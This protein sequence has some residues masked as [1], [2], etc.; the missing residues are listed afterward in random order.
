MVKRI[1]CL[2]LMLMLDREQCGTQ[3]RP[4]CGRIFCQDDGCG[5]CKDYKIFF[6][7]VNT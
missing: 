6:G 5:F 4:C 2:G 3:D 1:V 7:A